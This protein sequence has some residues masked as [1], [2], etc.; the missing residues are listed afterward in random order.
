MNEGFEYA[1]NE[2]TD[3]YNDYYGLV[4]PEHLV[5]SVFI[6][7]PELLEEASSGGIRDTCQREIAGRALSQ[8]IGVQDWPCY[9]DTDEYKKA[10]AIALIEQCKVFGI[11][12][13]E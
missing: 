5:L 13:L 7:D 2:I 11:V 12:I 8:L 3:I 9:G 6:K 10:P 1:V 4:V